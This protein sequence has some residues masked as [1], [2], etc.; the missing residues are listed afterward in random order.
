MTFIY[1]YSKMINV[2]SFFDF[3]IFDNVEV[4]DFTGP[5]EV[6]STTRKQTEE[7]E[8]FLYNVHLI[9]LTN[10]SISTRGGMEVKPHFPLT[11][12]LNWIK[13]SYPVAMVHG[14]SCMMNAAVLALFFLNTGITIIRGKRVAE[15]AYQKE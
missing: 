10:N 2:V 13:L 7:G 5:F 9:G 6:F 15:T 12:T 3:F 1:F 4:L 14:R 8:Q 11:Y